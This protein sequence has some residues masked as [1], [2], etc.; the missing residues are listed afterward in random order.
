[1]GL[2][3]P[4]PVVDGKRVGNHPRSILWD[5][6]SGNDGSLYLDELPRE[7][8]FDKATINNLR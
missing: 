2:G 8:Y 7:H 4:Q 3:D 5:A 1:M 6:A